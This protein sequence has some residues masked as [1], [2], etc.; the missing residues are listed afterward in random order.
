VSRRD[1]REQERGKR[2]RRGRLEDER[3][4][5]RRPIS[6]SREVR[7][8]YVACE[9]ETTEPDYLQYLNELGG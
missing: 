1:K 6:R 3:P 5:V 2:R 9:G 8:L 4:L 7:V